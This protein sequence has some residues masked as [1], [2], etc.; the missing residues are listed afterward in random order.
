MICNCIRLVK[1]FSK[2]IQAFAQD[3]VADVLGQVLGLIP[4]IKKH[5]RNILQW[6]THG[7]HP[8]KRGRSQ[9]LPLREVL[10]SG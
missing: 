6:Y 8:N 3:L 7:S 1:E 10:D 2:R 4:L 9:T 5:K